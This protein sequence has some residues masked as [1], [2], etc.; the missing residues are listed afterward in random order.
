ML[1]QM[2]DSTELLTWRMPVTPVFELASLSHLSVDLITIKDLFAYHF[3][4]LWRLP[5]YAL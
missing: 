2:V 5:L 1:T 4:M 3:L